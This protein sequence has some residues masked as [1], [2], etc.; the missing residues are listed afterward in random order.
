MARPTRNEQ[1][2]FT[3][4]ALNPDQVVDLASVRAARSSLPESETA[5]A[6][7]IFFQSMADPTRLRIIAALEDREL[8]GGDIAAAVG[9]TRSA[10]SHQLRTL[11]EAGLV[12]S[13][14]AGKQ[15]YYALDDEHVTSLF[16][17]ALDHARH[18]TKQHG[19]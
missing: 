4:H 12:R 1:L 15:V 3:Q 6:M 17:Q 8:C 14:R 13:R 2:A 16:Q 11:R 9:L 19:S 10:A 18:R 5:A 7:T